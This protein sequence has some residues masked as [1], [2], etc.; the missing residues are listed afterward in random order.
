VRESH[1]WYIQHALASRAFEFETRLRFR[2]RAIAYALLAFLFFD[3]FVF[4]CTA[5]SGK[6]D[7]EWIGAEKSF[8]SHPLA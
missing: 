4:F 2:E 7:R 5:N 6:V 1:N 8:C 3:F